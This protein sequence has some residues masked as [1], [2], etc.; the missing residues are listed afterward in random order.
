MSSSESFIRE[1]TEEM[2][3][4]KLHR[5]MRRY[6]WIGVVMVVGVVG[7]AAF[8]ELQSAAE[9]SEAAELGDAIIAALE[10]EDAS[11]RARSLSAIESVPGD[12]DAMLAMLIADAEIAAGREDQAQRVLDELTIGLDP[13]S[14]YYQLA[15]FKLLLLESSIGEVETVLREVEAFAAPGEPFRPLALEI[16]AIALLDSDRLQD[17]EVLLTTLVLDEQSPP[18]LK[19]RMSRLMLAHGFDLPQDAPIGDIGDIGQ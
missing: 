4:D 12:I 17:A 9:Q 15:K 5:F 10:L 19:R 14:P 2:R 7:G 13:G 3:R 16:K 8:F 6:A 1:V 11:E 18:D